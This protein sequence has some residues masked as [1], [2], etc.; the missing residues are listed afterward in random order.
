MDTILEMVFDNITDK[1]L[2][3]LSK[4]LIEE[5]LT[6]TRQGD[7]RLSREYHL[8]GAVYELVEWECKRRRIP[9]KAQTKEEGTPVGIEE[10]YVICGGCTVILW[11]INN[12]FPWE[13]DTYFEI[14]DR[15]KRMEDGD[16]PIAPNYC[17]NCGRKI[18]YTPFYE[19]A[20]EKKTEWEQEGE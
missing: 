11:P 12:D 19:Y 10:G 8:L 20:K 2:R 18:D 6:R 4:Q 17:C 13:D 15:K 5:M 1:G 9:P 16:V 3:A 14:K 7:T